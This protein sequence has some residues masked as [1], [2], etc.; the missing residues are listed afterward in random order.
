MPDQVVTA[1][2]LIIGN[3]ILSGRTQDANLGYIAKYL[4]ARGVTVR[5]AQVVPDIEEILIERI[6]ALRANYDYVLTTG[7]IGPT[8]DDI[9]AEC[10]A[11]AFNV[12]LVI[13]EEIVERI[14]QRPVEDEV[15]RSR[16]LMA[17]VPDGAS[18]IEN[19]TGGPQGFQMENVYVMAGI[20]FVLQNMLPNIEFKGGAVVQSKSIKVY[21]GESN[22]A[23]ELGRIQNEHPKLDLGS[24]PF[25]GES[26]YG[27]ILVIRGTDQGE[28]EAAAKKIRNMVIER[29]ETPED[30]DQA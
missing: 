28:I 6:N 24:Y 17:R 25:T 27:T 7:G 20:P 2:V 14:R 1:A 11:K 21:L 9:T 30:V 19:S 26:K 5:E 12:P 15:M 13:N 29:G 10:V 22:I 4:V 3:E 18:L 8:H 23:T 16:L